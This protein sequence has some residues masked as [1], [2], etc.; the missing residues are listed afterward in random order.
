MP[1][2]H[3]ELFV[4]PRRQHALELLGN[5][6]LAEAQQY[7]NQHIFQPTRAASLTLYLDNLITNLQNMIFNEGPAAQ[8]LDLPAQRDRT[9][10]R[11]QD[12][13]RVYFPTLDR[14][15]EA[16]ASMA[17]SK[18]HLYTTWPFGEHISD[19]NYRCLVCHQTI[20]FHTAP[21]HR[22]VEHLHG[23]CPAMTP[24]V[25]RRLPRLNRPPWPR[26]PPPPADDAAADPE[27][28]Q[29]DDE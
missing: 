24:G 2:A 16:A 20:P 7:F 22:M 27:L 11:I 12:Y 9:S 26:Q 6:N 14:G 15:P 23:G 5:G 10:R 28:Q 1:R 29:D 21:D 17:M 3:P 19:Q 13:L 8:Q 4:L 18:E 25:R